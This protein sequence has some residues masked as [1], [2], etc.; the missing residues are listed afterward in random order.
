MGIF[1]KIFWKKI[2]GET[3]FNTDFF[4]HSPNHLL[5]HSPIHPFTHLPIHPFTRYY[6]SLSTYYPFTYSTSSVLYVY[7]IRTLRIVGNF[8]LYNKSIYYLIIL[9]VYYCFMCSI[10]YNIT[11]TF[12]YLTI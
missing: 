7:Y 4:T 11:H 8:I 10:L 9:L 6:S 2:I 3:K 12:Y 1:G 5:S